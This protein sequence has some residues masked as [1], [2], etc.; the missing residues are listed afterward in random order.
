MTPALM[1][2]SQFAA[3]LGCSVR[4]VNKWCATGRIPASR[5]GRAWL[6]PADAV[7]PELLPKGR[8]KASG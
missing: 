5:L 7:R 1:S 4:L 6:I 3:K 8:K 2:C